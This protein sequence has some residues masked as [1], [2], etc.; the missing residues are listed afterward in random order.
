MLLRVFQKKKSIRVVQLAHEGGS[1][2][3]ALLIKAGTQLWAL[4]SARVYA[5]KDSGK[6]QEQ[7]QTIPHKYI[8][9]CTR[10]SNKANERI[11]QIV[12][13]GSI[14]HPIAHHY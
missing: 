13:V 8:H 1:G 11:D 10:L 6:K 3:A 7:D 12:N 5:R 2:S 14:S 4:P 9:M